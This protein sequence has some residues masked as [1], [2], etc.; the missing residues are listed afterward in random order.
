MTYNVLIV[1]EPDHAGLAAALADLTGLPPAAVDIADEDAEER[2]WAAPVLVTTAARTGDVRE[3]LDIYLAESVT[4]PS[5][6][7]AAAWLA[8]ALR[9][10]VIYPAEEDLPSAFWVATPTGNRIRARLDGEDGGEPPV[11][12][13]GAVE[14]PVAELPGASVRPLP[15]VIRTHVMPSPVA[16]RVGEQLGDERLWH[17]VNRLAAWEALV[18]RL[19]LGWPPD[20]WYPA[21]FYRGDLE[22]RDRL[23]VSVAEAPPDARAVLSAALSGIDD[24][25]RRLTHDD[26]GAA[27]AAALPGDAAD[28]PPDHWWWRHVPR[29]LPWDRQPGR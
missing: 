21:D 9:T 22:T 10:P 20:G 11:V 16:D 29:P 8:R 25:F 1:G 2:D 18:A 7:E 19:E 17:A 14:Y 28:A 15:D 26:G 4:A 13:V 5:E 23:A 12:R 3:A 24:A 27:L 6:R